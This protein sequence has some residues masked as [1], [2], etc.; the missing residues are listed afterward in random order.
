MSAPPKPT[1]RASL[2][3]DAGHIRLR[4][5]SDLIRVI[6]I[7]RLELGQAELDSVRDVLLSGQ[8]SRGE[9]VGAF[10]REL[11]KYLGVADCVV[12]NSGTAALHLALRSAHFPPGSEVI[13]PSLTF[14]AT[15]FAP[16]Y[17]GL[18]PVFADID[19]RTLNLSVGDVCRRIS[20]R[21]RAIIPVHYAGRCCA[22]PEF[23]KLAQEH[24]L[25][26]LEDAAHAIGATCAGRKIGTW[27]PL[28]AFSFFATKNLAGG[29][30]GAVACQDSARA[31]EA[32]LLR[33]H[34]IRRPT[35]QGEYAP[36]QYDVVDL[37][38]N[39][40]L[41]HLN[42]A[43]LKCQLATLDERIAKRKRLAETYTRCLGEIAEIRCPVPAAGEEH[44]FH[45]YTVM[46]DSRL[47]PFR[48]HIVTEMRRRGVQTGV[49]YRPAHQF[50]YFRNK[51][52]EP[53]RLPVTEAV[54]N[55]ILTLPF[56]DSL[57][58]DDMHCVRDALKES[59]AAH[60]KS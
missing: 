12:V 8:L 28:T 26:V 34:G 51:Y 48:D 13:V 11:A 41:S 57:T 9:Y 30:G 45:L 27:S 6:P 3:A 37:G 22:M 10:E 7:F 17:C 15:A 35:P 40:N 5:G 60:L 50:S 33:G 19:E 38:Y 4:G 49:Y 53:A 55:R 54:A 39:Y 23:L 16:E 18:R 29:E 2:E 1:S 24:G 20:P 25:E 58:E 14:V 21:T 46:L 59:I 56:Y 47:A 44:V 31:A 32:R 36:G 52:A 42:I 43:V